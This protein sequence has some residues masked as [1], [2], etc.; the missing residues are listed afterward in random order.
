MPT[1]RVPLRRR[2]RGELNSD[3]E[4]ALWLGVGRN[5]SFPFADEDEAAELWVR[6]KPRI[7]EAHARNGRRPYAWWVYEAETLGLDYPGYET[8]A[9]YLYEHGQL[10]AEETASEVAY[11]REQFE[12]CHEPGFGYCSGPGE[13]LHGRE[14]REAHMA[15]ADIPRSLVEKWTRERNAG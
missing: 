12:R 14:A 4:M 7:M 2:V 13:W 8:E 9:S 1:N 10:G 5:G 6:H 15:W 3:Q 11:W